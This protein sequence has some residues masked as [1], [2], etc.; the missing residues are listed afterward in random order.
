M[1]RLVL[2]ENQFQP[3]EG[4]YTYHTFYDSYYRVALD[5]CLYTIPQKTINNRPT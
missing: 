3:Q 1:D 5:G 4:Q 2:A